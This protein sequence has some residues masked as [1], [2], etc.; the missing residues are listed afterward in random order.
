MAKKLT[1][2]VPTV[3]NLRD[4]VN[5]MYIH[6]GYRDNG[7]DKM[8]VEQRDL[9]LFISG[10]TKTCDECGR[11]VYY[12]EDENPISIAT[13]ALTRLAAP[14]NCGCVPCVG[15]CI[16]SEALLLET[17]TMRSIAREALKGMGVD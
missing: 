13:A 3:E 5:H 12:A 8:D 14:R 17:E 10:R 9:Y 6:S 15:Q 11:K 1:A 7:Y 4:L 2:P 16:S